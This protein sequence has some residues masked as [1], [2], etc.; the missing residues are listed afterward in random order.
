MESSA[1]RPDSVIV[2]DQSQTPDIR[3]AIAGH[4]YGE[5]AVDSSCDMA[6]ESVFM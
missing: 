2:V 6:D 3:D 4:T 1:V 5:S